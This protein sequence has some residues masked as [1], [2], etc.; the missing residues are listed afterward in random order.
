M[1]MDAIR[2]SGIQRYRMVLSNPRKHLWD[3][4]HEVFT[5]VSYGEGK[6]F[7]YLMSASAFS[8]IFAARALASAA[9]AP[10]APVHLTG[11]G[12][13]VEFDL[14][15]EVQI[16]RANLVVTCKLSVIFANVTLTEELF[17][18]SYETLVNGPGLRFQV[19]ATGLGNEVVDVQ[20]AW[21]SG[22]GPQD[23]TDVSYG[24]LGFVDGD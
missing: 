11:S 15:L 10:N 4:E 18:V 2:T 22:G 14:A 19:V 5:G 20:L 17:Q 23:E 9:P 3:P 1:Q 12:N 16:Q 8:G 24:P 13:K 6:Y 7:G 21:V